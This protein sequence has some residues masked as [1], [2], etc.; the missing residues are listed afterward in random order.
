MMVQQISVFVE[1]KPGQLSEF[2][3]L[4]EKSE[5][6]MRALSIA[7]AEDFGIL[8]VIVDDSYN[9]VRVLKDAGY[10][11]SLTPVLAVEIA[12]KP[13][14]LAKVVEALDEG[15]INLEYMYAFLAPK[16]DSAYMI[17]RV[18]DNDKAETVLQA[19]GFRLITQEELHDLF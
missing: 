10:V 19:A 13:G 9:T 16:K 1:N 18:A 14:S 8:R 4:L 11:C 12:D 6:D 15:G 3:K 2:T 5:I 7:E 17:F